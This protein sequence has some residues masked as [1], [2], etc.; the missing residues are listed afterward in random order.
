VLGTVTIKDTVKTAL[1]GSSRAAE[2]RQQLD[3]AALTR[4]AAAS[5]DLLD[6]NVMA[7]AWR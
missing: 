3:H 7:D 1:R 6:A 2:R 5:K 4:F